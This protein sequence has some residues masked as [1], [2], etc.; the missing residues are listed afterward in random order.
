MSNKGGVRAHYFRNGVSL[1]G[2]HKNG[3]L[4]DLYNFVI[5]EFACR[6]CWKMKNREP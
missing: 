6:E 2:R 1:C 3:M 4:G 5:K